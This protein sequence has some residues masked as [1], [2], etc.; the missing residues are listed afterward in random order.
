MVADIF[1]R[2]TNRFEPSMLTGVHVGGRDFAPRWPHDWQSARSLDRRSRCAHVVEV[3][4]LWIRRRKR[5]YHRLVLRRYV[6]HA[7]GRIE[8]TAVPIRTATITRL[9]PRS[10]IAT[11]DHA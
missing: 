9:C 5:R 8:C 1:R 10:L 3:G 4:E 11:L 7:R 2:R 6:H